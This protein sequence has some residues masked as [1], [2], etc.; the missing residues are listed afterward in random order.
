M[1]IPTATI[2][3]QRLSQQRLTQNPLAT[4]AEVVAWMGAVQAQEYQ[5]AKWSLYLRLQDATDEAIERA[6]ADGAI[7]RTH[8]LRP[9]WH[10]VTPADIRWMLALT[11]AR[12]NAQD[13]GMC[14]QY[15]LDDGL[16]ARSNAA[17]ESAL[18]GGRHLTRAEIGAVLAAAGIVAT[19]LRLG[20]ILHRAE[21]DGLICSGPRRGKQFTY[22]LLDERAP[23]TTRI[24]R[25][26]ALTELAR[27]YYV[28]HG[29]ATAHDFAWWSGLTVTDARAGAEMAGSSLAREV[30]DGRTYWFAASPLPAPEPNEAVFLL[31]TYDEFLV[32]YA[33]FD[34][35]RR[36]GRSAEESGTFDST[37]VI[38]GRVM[39]TWRRTIQK[40][41]V[42]IAVTPF[43]P[44]S[45]AERDAVER[46]AQR[47]GAFVNLTAQCTIK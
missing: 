13:A 15:E 11:A 42:A 18:R 44:L 22:A 47:Y 8:I 37:L 3:Q 24:S 5:G 6:F 38:G 36:G 30:I 4:A 14:R 16:F 39:G 33:G 31:P 41:A 21:T 46:A 27:R 32:G 17:L 2:A 29:P 10:F 20:L 23:Q 19:G 45:D 40:A 12:V 35:L 7:V 43:A 34:A 9:T 28:S 26:E 25:D 1:S